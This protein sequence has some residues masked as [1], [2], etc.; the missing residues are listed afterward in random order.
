M[1]IFLVEDGSANIESARTQFAKHELVVAENAKKALT[2]MEK[3]WDFDLYLTDLNVIQ[4]EGF[5]FNDPSKIKPADLLPIGFVV[6]LSAMANNKP[7]ILLS[8]ENAHDSVMG[9]LLEKLL[10]SSNGSLISHISDED[11][12]ATRPGSEARFNS[13]SYAPLLY[14]NTRPNLIETGMG[15][16]KD[17]L[18]ELKKT[19]WSKLIE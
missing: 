10:G 14:L 7:C 12:A 3:I 15:P 4:G 13:Q 1:K 9:I 19:R 18:G 16:G 6:A 17:W 2:I 8:Q 11:R 5:V